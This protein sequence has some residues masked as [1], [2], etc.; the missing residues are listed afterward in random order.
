MAQRTSESEL[1]AARIVEYLTGQRVEPYD[2]CVE[3][4]D[5]HDKSTPFNGRYDFH[6]GQAG[7]LEVTLATSRVAERNSRDWEPYSSPQSASLLRNHWF[8]A[9]ESTAKVKVPRS[10]KEGRGSQ[11]FLEVVSSALAELE[12][13]GVSDVAWGSP[14]F[15]DPFHDPD[16]PY[17]K[18][19]RAGVQFGKATSGDGTGA[20]SVTVLYGYDA[21]PAADEEGD[22]KKAERLQRKQ[23]AKE[24]RKPTPKTAE[25][26]GL[27]P[28]QWSF[29]PGFVARLERRRAEDEQREAAVIRSL[30]ADHLPESEIVERAREEVARRIDLART[31]TWRERLP[32]LPEARKAD[33]GTDLVD[34]LE[35]EFSLHPDLAMKLLRADPRRMRH[36]V[37]F[38]LTWMRAPAWNR[39][40]RHG[41]LP[42]RDPE[43]PDGVTGVWVGSL[44]DP[45][46][47]LHWDGETGWV[48]H[49]PPDSLLASICRR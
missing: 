39:L 42:A 43:L 7:A 5:F 12:R 26:D 30:F 35:V 16:C 33:A 31:M 24:G 21:M 8:V 11:E 2:K 27:G 47:V 18:L 14:C 13:R 6:V 40:T 20:I 49:D 1:H 44:T 34:L 10:R 3:C 32:S 23:R 29:N 15:S 19:R 38:W 4:D 41:L 28:V 22:R 46:H 25:P 36:E 45:S 48:R 9:V 17:G 37:F